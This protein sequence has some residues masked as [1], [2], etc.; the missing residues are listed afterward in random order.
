M[1]ITINRDSAVLKGR[2]TDGLYILAEI[3]GMRPACPFCGAR[4]TI[5][6]VDA[7]GLNTLGRWSCPNAT[8]H[9]V[10]D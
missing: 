8:R 10:L 1:H 7:G 6:P 9:P 5:A 2:G 3:A 4:V